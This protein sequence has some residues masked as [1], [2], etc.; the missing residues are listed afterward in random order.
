MRRR[1]FIGLIGSV[2]ATWPLAAH[3]QRPDQTRRIGI[4]MRQSADDPEGKAEFAALLQ[5]LQAL[6]WTE[7]RNVRIDVRWAGGDSD[8]IRRYAVELVKLAPEVVVA[9]GGTVVGALQQ[10][11]QT[12]PI[13]FVDVT[14]PIG[15]G[16]VAS[17]ARPG[18][19]ATGFTS[20]ESAIGGKWLEMLK[21]IAPGITR[22][23]VFRD[24]IITAGIGQL[25]AIQS[26]AASFGVEVS[27]IDVRNAKEI[28]RA[29]IEFARGMN[30]GLIASTDPS[31][32]VHRQLIVT[33]AARHGLP[34]VYPFRYFVTIGGLVSYGPDIVDQFRRAA[35][36]VDRI[37]KGDNPG[38][39]PVEQPTKLAI[40]INLKTAKALGLSIPPWLLTTADEVIE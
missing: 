40:V 7:D 28:E 37:L 11:S 21:Q 30:G 25:A 19:N 34:A 26:A 16:Y 24:P 3:A 15:R 33:L 39:L 36:Y 6:G 10:A 13:V 22:V 31:T 27:P 23:A 1:E 14:D 12:L 29:V 18:G 5:G 17:L 9:S 35:S 32:V 20:Y 38:N 8:L 2:A 4:L